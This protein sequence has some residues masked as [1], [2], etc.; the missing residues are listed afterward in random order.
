[1]S[2]APGA[3]GNAL[4]V[5][6]WVSGFEFGILTMRA[7]CDTK[8]FRYVAILYVVKFNSNVMCIEVV[9]C[10]LRVEFYFDRGHKY[11]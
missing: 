10:V 4:C 3:P 9:S 5:C 2:H 7:K 6:D 8:Q 1:V 11:F